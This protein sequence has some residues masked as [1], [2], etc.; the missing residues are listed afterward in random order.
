MVMKDLLTGLNPE[1]KKACET[2]DGSMLVLAGAG[3]GK[4]RVLT[5]RLANLILSGKAKPYQILA[6]TFTNKAASEMR[7]RTANLTGLNDN[8]L[9]IGTFHSLSARILRQYAEHVGLSSSFV[10]IDSDDQLRLMQ[11]LLTE[12]G[13]DDNKQ[14]AKSLLYQI[15]F[16][17]N[18]GW[19][20]DQLSERDQ[21]DL[22]SYI[23]DALEKISDNPNADTSPNI[24]NIYAQYQARLLQMNA[25]DFG[26]LLLHVIHIFNKHPDILERIHN[27]F[28]YVMVDE[29]QD[30]NV[31]QYLWLRL[32]TQKHRNICCVGD[33]DQAIYSWRGAE[34]QNILR[35]Q[36]DFPEASIIRLET[37]YRST[38][39][40][41]QTASHLI[42]HNHGRLGKILH[43]HDGNMG[44]KVGLYGLYSG[45]QEASKVAKLIE[46]Y[47]YQENIPLNEN[48][49]LV[50]TSAQTRSFEEALLHARIPYQIIGG[51]R[52]YEREEIRDMIAY[53]RLIA[54]PNDDLACMRIINKPTRGIGAS[55]LQMVKDN[56][57]RQGL[58]IL[59]FLQNHL[60]SL[61]KLTAR[62][63][64]ALENFTMMMADLT[65]LKN[66][67]SLPELTD[68]ILSKT[69][70]IESLE[71]IAD[72]NKRD[73]KIDNLKE[74]LVAQS[75]LN[76]LEE[77]LEHISLVMDNA[78]SYQKTVFL[79]TIHAAKGLEFENIFL[80]G[81]EEGLFPSARTVEEEGK[82]GLEEER[83]LAYV[84]LTRAKKHA[85]IFHAA[86]RRLYG[87]W[88]MAEPSRFINELPE[89][90]I[91]IMKP[92][93]L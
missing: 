29:Y 64:K 61:P 17:K 85:H 30:T 9:S 93:F 86:G 59:P 62:S 50:R 2:L 58:A 45:E 10:I 79:M 39:H 18:R 83:R 1:Q 66:N 91:E 28:R 92:D 55:S 5:T 54:N 36:E 38:G 27:R 34:I 87:Q 56:A 75:N 72:K 80:A 13:I 49:I 24:G 41:L 42:S 89:Q 37:N 32:F 81:W 12:M 52:F 67:V 48:A 84:A 11:T 77:F 15:D 69:H 57:R 33:D 60:D 90:S 82:Q 51:R 3:T 25:V 53:L 68:A 43:S 20:P 46:R 65:T 73:S 23:Y 7:T 70:Y 21:E 22:H 74:L 71:K 16:Y 8:E 88:K 40:I 19:A 14:I 35:F 31:A 6:V 76:S 26:D 44:R 63:R 47:Q 4:T 78:T